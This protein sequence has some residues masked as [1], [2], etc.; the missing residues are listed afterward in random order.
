MLSQSIDLSLGFLFC[1]V[2]VILSA[3]LLNRAETIL[4]LVDLTER[5]TININKQNDLI[6]YYHQENE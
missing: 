1:K 2:D 4:A 5:Q 3:S 6:R